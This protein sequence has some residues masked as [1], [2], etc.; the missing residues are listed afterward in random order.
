MHRAN[1]WPLLLVAV[2]IAALAVLATMQVRWIGEVSAAHEQ[3]TR[4]EMQSAA[5][6]FAEEVDRD[7][8]SVAEAFLVRKIDAAALARRYDVWQVIGRDPRLIDAIYVID[9]HSLLR[10]DP[11]RRAL[12]PIAWLPPL[13]GLRQRLAGRRLPEFGLDPDL[14]AMVIPL[15]EEHESRGLMVVQLDSMVLTRE[16]FPELGRRYFATG[17]NEGFDVAVANG[18]R[19]VYRS[20]PQWPATVADA[21]PDGA[22]PLLLA[23][24]R[25]EEREREVVREGRTPPSSWTLLVRHHGEPLAESFAAIRRRDLAIA[26]AILLLLGASVVILAAVARRADRLRQQ[27]LEFVAGITHELNTPLAAL[28]SA[29]QN[30]ADG[31]P[32]DTALYGA[33]IV[34]E[35]HRLIDLVE[36]VLQFSG[37]QTRAEDRRDDIVDPR[38]TIAEAVAQ[39]RWFAD[40][41]GVRVE[42]TAPETLPCLRGDSAALTRAVQNLVANAIRHGSEGGWVGVRAA[43]D[44]GFVNIIVEDRGAGIA[45][46]DLPHLFEPFYR[47]RNA[48]TRGSGLGL[49]IVD[50][51]ARAHGG[52]ITVAKGN[53]GGAAFTLR[54]PA[55]PVST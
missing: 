38:V 32:V 16:L 26:L 49:T 48:Q 1:R 9:D 13:A 50:R 2:L 11:A 41:R 45:A 17:S 6:R 44:D 55:R 30:L 40:E 27:Q 8:L 7:L 47:G 24:R 23:R 25:T 21:E 39:C 46:V 35:T 34:K 53:E 3:R 5:R 29:G 4:A 43:C 42:T 52:S 15:G 12:D 31:L 36:Q 33:T 18:D 10:F 28:G 20:V 37:L 54:L 19:I 14:P 51:V 22:W